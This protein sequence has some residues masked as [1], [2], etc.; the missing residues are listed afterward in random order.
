[1]EEFESRSVTMESETEMAAR[2]LRE[3][4]SVAWSVHSA[5]VPAPLPPSTTL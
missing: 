5:T 1:M 2:T 4:F 3:R